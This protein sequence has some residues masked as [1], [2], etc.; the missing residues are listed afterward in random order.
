MYLTKKRRRICQI[1]SHITYNYIFFRNIQL[2]RVYCVCSRNHA[3]YT[4]IVRQQQKSEL[5]SE[6]YT[7]THT[8]IHK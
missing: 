5:Y 7:L 8:H 1:L 2:A 3:P 4:N 6:E